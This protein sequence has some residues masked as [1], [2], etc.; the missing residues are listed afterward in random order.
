[1]GMMEPFQV[2]EGAGNENNVTVLIFY[3]VRNWNNV[4]V[5]FCCNFAHLWLQYTVEQ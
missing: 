2:L 3:L 5:T 1:M 4:P